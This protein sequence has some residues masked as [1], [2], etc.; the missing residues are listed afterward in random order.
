MA[1]TN[2][3]T[4]LAK[5]KARLGIDDSDHN[6]MLEAIVTAVSRQ[7]DDECGRRFYAT[8]ETRDYT[9]RRCDEILV[10]DLLSVTSLS[11]D[12]DADGDH[13]T[14]WDA[15]DYVLGP[16]NAQLASTPKPYWFV[17]VALSSSRSFPAGVRD[18]V[19]IVGSFGHSSATP[20]VVEE[21]CL[22]QCGLAYYARNA[23]LGTSGSGDFGTETATDAGGAGLHPFTRRMLAPY[24]L[25]AVV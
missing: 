4:T 2:G 23:P 7:I 3:Y 20:A 16:P 25:L 6:A 15:A 9:A 10:D 17:R 18:G 21:A 14:A 5:L 1:I 11:T 12:D 24:R 13:E 19:R 22:L 8:T